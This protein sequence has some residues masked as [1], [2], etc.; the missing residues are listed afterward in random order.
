MYTIRQASIRAGVPVALLRQWERRYG[1]VQPART[2]SGYRLYDD[3]A[4]ARLRQM[5]SLVDDGWTPSAAAAAL[6][7]GED[8]PRPPVR[9]PTEPF[10]PT[11]SGGETDLV[12]ALVSAAVALDTARMDA[13]LDEMF[14]RGSF[15]QT[16]ERFLLPALRQIGDAWATGRGDVAAEHAASHAI[17]HR[18]GA[19]YQAAGRA[20]SG[21]RPVLVGLPPGSRHELGAL[22][23]SVAARRSGVP[24]LFL[25]ADLPARDWTDAAAQS[26][27]MAAVI[28]VVTAAD[29]GPAMD[30]AAALDAAHPHLMLVFGGT[31]APAIPHSD[32]HRRLPLGLTDA[33]D[34]LRSMLG[35]DPSTNGRRPSLP[36]P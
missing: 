33:V 4:I 14:V 15:E 28:G 29:V 23:F 31:A 6:L 10:A 25:G 35:G 34:V 11:R 9:E 18:L 2:A 1:I 27:A 19:A 21:Q 8:L 12:A 26:D 30:V 3:A 16:T 7:A 20:V 24:V 5:R 32:E 17:L 13:V 22:A 36:R